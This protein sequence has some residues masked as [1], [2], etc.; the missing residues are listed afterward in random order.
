MSDSR[1]HHK[2]EFNTWVAMKYRCSSPKSDSWHNYGGRGI[3]VCR[4]WAES[5]DNFFAD[6]G[7][8][9]SPKHSIHRIN[10]NGNYDPGNCQWATALEHTKNKRP[11]RKPQGRKPQGRKHGFRAS[12]VTRAFLVAKAIGIHEP[13][14][15]ICLP[16][17]TKLAVGSA[18]AFQK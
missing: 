6:M 9:P 16:N 14:I 18:S 4:R 1:K 17:G 11:S 15:T 12:D 2:S 5:F 8:K 7:S 13:I 3:T 10:N